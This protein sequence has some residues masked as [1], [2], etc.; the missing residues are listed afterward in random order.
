M[1]KGRQ[2]RRPDVEQKTSD[3]AGAVRRNDR[4]PFGYS[5]ARVPVVAPFEPFVLKVLFW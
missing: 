3:G 4:W 5:G 2:L 1:K